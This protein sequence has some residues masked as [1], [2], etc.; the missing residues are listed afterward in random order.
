MA[1]TLVTCY[2]PLK[3]KYPS[4]QYLRW[5][6]DFLKLDASIVLFTTPELAGLFKE[7]RSKA[8]PVNDH[9]SFHVVEQRFED[10]DAWTLYKTEWIKHHALDPERDN[11]SP[12]LYAIWAQKAFFVKR[13]IDLNPFGTNYF[14]WCDIGAFRNGLDP[15]IQTSFPSV[16]H[17]PADRILMSSVGPSLPGDNDVRPDGIRGD[18]MHVNRI[19]GGL[20]GGGALGCIRWLHTY[21]DMLERYFATGRF[22]GKDQSVMLSAYLENRTSA[23]IVKST[24]PNIDIWFFLTHLCS[25]H[26]VHYEL[27]ASYI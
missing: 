5:A 17:L 11:H 6:S 14:F 23:L 25:N 16:R 21:K 9:Y 3:S 26:V 24:V 10:L 20:W 12:E 22:A 13:A 1:C 19:V 8:H 2:Y 7:I 27:D 18:F 15:V 4:E